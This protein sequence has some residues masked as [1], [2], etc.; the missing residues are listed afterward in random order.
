MSH[1]SETNQIT[2]I[3]AAIRELRA[4]PTPS[5]LANM[6][7]HPRDDN[8]TFRD[9][10]HSYKI[11]HDGKL[12]VPISVTT[13]IHRYFSEF[14]ADLIIDKMMKG[15]NWKQ[16]K[17][18]GKTKD[19]IKSEWDNNGKEA[20][21]LGT[22]MHADIEFFLNKDPV[23]YPNGR[24]FQFF[25]AF[26]ND[27][28]N[29][30]PTFHPYRT[31]WLVYDEDEGVAGSIDCILADDQ[32]QLMILDWKRSKEIKLNNKWEKGLHPFEHFEDCNHSHYSLQLNF[33]RH[34][35]ET[36]YNKKVVF[37]MLVILHPNQESYMCYP[38]SHIDLNV[39]WMGIASGGVQH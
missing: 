37:M 17:Y 4:K 11:I 39:K 9:E 3:D 12:I 13:L 30:Y 27:F 31:E 1:I 36:K 25:M 26:W 6:N 32:N 20:A 34:M 2:D 16:S 38:I 19:E 21:D 24:E 5:Y 33:Y 14:N 29:K 18:Y 8:I 23:S 10:D 35:L 7:K 28:K 22:L 15:R